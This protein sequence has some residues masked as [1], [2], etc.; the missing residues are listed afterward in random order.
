MSPVPAAESPRTPDR[1]AAIAMSPSPALDIEAV[2]ADFP[3]LATKVHGKPLAFLDS[4]ASSQRPHAVIGAVKDLYETSYANIHR[5]VYALSQKS[6][7]AYE[8]AREKV[9]AFL[10]APEAKHCLFTSGTTQ[11][12]NLVAQSWGGA[13]LGPGDEVLVTEMEHHSNLVPW[14]LIAKARGAKVRAIPVTDTGELDMARLG[15]FLTE[16]TKLLAVAHVSNVL[17]TVNPV[18]E[19]CEKAHAVGA[20][21]LVDGAQGVP[22]MAVDVTEIGCDFYVFSGHKMFAPSGIGVLWGR[23]ELL[24]AMPPYLGGGGMI[25]TVTI[26]ESTFL[27]CPERFE[28]GT[29]NIAGA[30]GLGAAID[31]LTG[32][33]MDRVAAWEG[34]L[35]AY[36]TEKLLEIPGLRMIGTAREKASV[37]SF[38]VEGLHPHDLGTILDKKGVAVR[39]G[40]HCAQPL[41]KRFGVPATTRASLGVYN[42]REDLDR[43]AEGVRFA[44]ELFA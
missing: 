33:G 31:Y 4:G 17:G 42:T 43:L 1:E 20:V 7:L 27:G 35:L 24:E 6:T 11:S 14:Q 21:V 29:P 5:G 38:V 8:A 22:H 40:H 19:L 25:E 15:E 37:M 36:G 30:I 34:E 26:E 32:L 10:G 13:N 39:C 44:Q 9:R 12:I 23:G 2:R 28:A 41:M 18:R 3:I 16:K